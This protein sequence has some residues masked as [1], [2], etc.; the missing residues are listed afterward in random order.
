MFFIYLSN[1]FKVIWMNCIVCNK[2]NGWGWM[3]MKWNCFG[4][5]SL[6][7][8]PEE[9]I[10]LILFLFVI[11]LI[12]LCCSKK[13]KKNWKREQRTD[14]K[15][16]KMFGHHHSLIPSIEWEPD[17][18]ASSKSKTMWNEKNNII[19][20]INKLENRKGK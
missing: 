3:W 1:I 8:V 17:L 20:S 19:L 18:S 6:F 12:N 14:I 11:N 15:W 7:V 10:L 9:S 13:E 2:G 16:N 5:Y 4:I